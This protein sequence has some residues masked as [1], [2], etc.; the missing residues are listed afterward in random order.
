MKSPSFPVPRALRYL[1]LFVMLVVPL[2]SGVGVAAAA[3]TVP[4]TPSPTP[5][6]QPSP[7]T[8]VP[9][10][11]ATP[12]P[13]RPVQVVPRFTYKWIDVNLTKQLL[14][15]YEGAR[16]IFS[17]YIS[18][19]VAKHKTAPGIFRIYA[20]LT[21]QRMTGGVGAEHY[22]LPNVPYVMYFYGGNAIHGT[23]WHHNFGHPMSHGCVNAPTSASAFLFNWAP[24]GTT[25]RVHY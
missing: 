2:F 13:A 11:T 21:S 20:K 9:A 15:A 4:P 7:G 8:P 3:Q 5:Q 18:S 10:I 14:I 22:D 17:T 12:A 24:L 16:P 23:Y 19:G 25:V 6:A 1:V